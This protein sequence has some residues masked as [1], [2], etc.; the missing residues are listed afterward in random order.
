MTAET[1]GQIRLGMSEKAVKDMLG[2]PSKETALVEWG[3]D[4]LK[5]KQ[6]LYLTKGV[7]L[8]IVKDKGLQVESITIK[9]PC[10]L[11]TSRGIG[12]GNSEAEILNAYRSEIDPSENEAG[13]ESIVAG[14]VYGGVIFKM[15]NGK[16]SE[17]FVGASAE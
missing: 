13:A 1:I 9:R 8:G 7:E 14:T 12:I 10:S 6:I 2:K 3:A 15:R 5:H 17:I 11:K 16:V 4:G